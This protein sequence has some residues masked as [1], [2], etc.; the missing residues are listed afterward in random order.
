MTENENKLLYFIK[1]K[2]I[3]VQIPLPNNHGKTIVTHHNINYCLYHFIEGETVSAAESLKNAYIPGLLGET[4]ALLH[5]IMEKANVSNFVEKNLS[6]MVS[7]FALKEIIKVGSGEDVQVILNTMNED[8]QKR[9]ESL[10][11]QLIHRD[12]H[13]FN[14]IFRDNR[15]S[16]VID[17]EIA[18]VNVRIFDLC[19]CWTSVLNEVFSDLS[20]REDWFRFVKEMIHSYNRMNS[21]TDFERN[22]V[23]HV[24]LCIQLIFMAYFSNNRPLYE[25]NKAMFMWIYENKERFSTKTLA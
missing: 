15:L 22:S 9:I 18:E 23:W 21:L 24:M 1:S 25:S 19:Y 12:A 16:G 7:E 8:F 2:G 17:F 14:F 5:I 6:K 13:I 3:N 4:L 10:P 20:A 11:K